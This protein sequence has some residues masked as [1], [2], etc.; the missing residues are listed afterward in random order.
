M[1]DS[2]DSR[3]GV[4][5]RGGARSW[6]DLSVTNYIASPQK[7]ESERSTQADNTR[8]HVTTTTTSHNQCFFARRQ[9]YVTVRATLDDQRSTSCVGRQIHVKSRYAHLF[10]EASVVQFRALNIEACCDH[11]R[12]YISD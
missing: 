9:E 3:R 10:W 12:K 2:P 5:P 8:N 7:K 1:L 4:L 6:L 11:I